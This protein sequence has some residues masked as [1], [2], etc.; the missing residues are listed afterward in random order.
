MCDKHDDCGDGTDEANCDP[1]SSSPLPPTLSPKPTKE[2]C[3]EEEFFCESGAC[4]PRDKLCDGR[5]NCIDGEDEEEEFCRNYPCPEE[6]SFRCPGGACVHVNFCDGIPDCADAY[7][8]SDCVSK[9]EYPVEDDKTNQEDIAKDSELPKYQD[10]ESSS[11]PPHHRE[12]SDEN[13]TFFESGVEED[14][15][16]AVDVHSSPSSSAEEEEEEPTT[17]FDDAMLVTNPETGEDRGG[18]HGNL[19]GTYFGLFFLL[20]FSLIFYYQQS[21]Y[22]IR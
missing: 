6:R 11:E 2:L 15:E 21:L 13:E 17:S 5:P 1:I 14:N 10:R 9:N 7:D 19:E 22:Y 20:P 8:E 3:L 4:I 16:P 18:C 12:P